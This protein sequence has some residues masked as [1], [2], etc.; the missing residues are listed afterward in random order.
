MLAVVL[1][2]LSVALDNF[3]ASIGIG[4]GG[5][6]AR[7]RLQIGLIFGLFE[8]GMPVVGLLI[9]H[10]VAH[11]IGGSARWLGGGLLI[12]AGIYALLAELIHPASGR[13]TSADGTPKLLLVGLALSIDNLV[14]G[15]ALGSEHVAVLA[16]GLIIAA[17]SVSLSL[18]GLEFG[19]RIGARFGERGEMIGGVV[20]VGV[21]IAV[22]AGA[23]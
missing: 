12:A 19:S 17:T 4:V 11:V 9:G 13:R 10:R 21:G 6:T 15:F 2:A 16:A 20:L 22:A 8:G 3:A 23:L 7:L 5:V 18:V 1:V 14:I